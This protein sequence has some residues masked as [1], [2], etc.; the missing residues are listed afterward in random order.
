MLVF[1]VVHFS[2]AHQGLRNRWPGAA[3]NLT[4]TTLLANLADEKLMI[5]L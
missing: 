3:F 2:Q 5:S 1:Y 4:F